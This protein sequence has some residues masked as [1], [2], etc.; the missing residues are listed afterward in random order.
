M[1]KA[2]IT[3][4]F[5]VFLSLPLSNIFAAE[6]EYSE[7]LIPK[8]TSNNLP[9]GVTSTSNEFSYS[10]RSFDGDF[11]TISSAWGSNENTA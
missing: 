4:L 9:S 7:N 8:M 2:C 10:Y 3:I 5:L 1:K 6:A 11:A